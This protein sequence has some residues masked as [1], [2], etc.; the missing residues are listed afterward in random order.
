MLALAISAVIA[1]AG[2]CTHPKAW[3]PVTITNTTEH[4][5]QVVLVPPSP[6]SSMWEY[7]STRAQYPV[8]LGP[9][10]TFVCDRSYPPPR[11]LRRRSS[12]FVVLL[13]PE[14]GDIAEHLL[15]THTVIN[16]TVTILIDNRGISAFDSAG[17]PVPVSRYWSLYGDPTPPED[18]IETFRFHFPQGL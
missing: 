7:V 15:P 6:S 8:V 9:G 2:G 3:R 4:T 12:A 14:S 16:R 17:Q 1:C 18:D 10:E 5:F 11:S 13:R